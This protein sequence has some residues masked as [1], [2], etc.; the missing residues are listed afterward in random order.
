MNAA[1]LINQ[2]S[3]EVEYYSPEE[4]TNAARLCMG[5]IEL[6]P[7]SCP[8]ANLTINADQFFT[9]EDDGLKLL[10]RA[11]TV[12]MNHPFHK[13]ENKCK[14]PHDLCTKKTCQKRGYHIDEDLPGNAPWINKILTAYQNFERRLF[15]GDQVEEACILTYALTSEVWLRPLLCYPHVLLH[16][17]TSFRLPGGRLAEQNTKG[18]MITYLGLNVFAF[19]DAYKQFGSVYVPFPVTV[20]E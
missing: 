14:T 2:T 11:K 13:Q 20:H 4:L 12:W 10:W 15:A 5:S 9:K 8:E 3:G 19:S 7:A 16:G 17:R 6:D 18:C 1:Q